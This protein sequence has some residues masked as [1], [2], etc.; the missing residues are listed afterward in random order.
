MSGDDGEGGSM[1]AMSGNAWVLLAGAALLITQEAARETPEPWAGEVHPTIADLSAECRVLVSV[2]EAARRAGCSAALK[3]D[4]EDT[5]A[6]VEAICRAR[7]FDAEAWRQKVRRDYLLGEL[8]PAF[9][10]ALNAAI[11][12]RRR[13]G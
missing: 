6:E 4:L 7:G 3:P 12:A 13:R 1:L 2:V 5:A 11:R 9:V 10:Q 8:K